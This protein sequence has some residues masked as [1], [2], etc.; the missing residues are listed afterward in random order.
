[1]DYRNLANNKSIRNDLTS[2]KRYFVGQVQKI[3]DPG[4]WPSEFERLTGG[5]KE[6]R[7]DEIRGTGKTIMPEDL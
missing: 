2:A 3:L 4:R 5:V 6:R 7:L 1:V